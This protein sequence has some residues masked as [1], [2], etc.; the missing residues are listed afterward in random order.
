MLYASKITQDPKTYTS[1][2]NE[3]IMLYASKITQD[4]KTSLAFYY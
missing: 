3:K 1:Y 2:E 4:P